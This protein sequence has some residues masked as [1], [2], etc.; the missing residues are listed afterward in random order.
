M[1]QWVYP[2]DR[3]RLSR[4]HDLK[5]K[6]KRLSVGGRDIVV[7]NSQPFSTVFCSFAVCLVQGLLRP[8]IITQTLPATVRTG[9]FVDRRAE[10]SS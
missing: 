3:G 5:V 1:L 10:R 6:S 7:C 8:G 9:V 2:P 4:Y